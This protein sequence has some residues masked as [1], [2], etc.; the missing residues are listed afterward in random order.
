MIEADVVSE[1]D[2]LSFNGKNCIWCLDD[3]TEK[4]RLRE[5]R[6]H[7]TRHQEILAGCDVYIFVLIFFSTL[8][9]KRS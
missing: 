4:W 1:I 9:D 5:S 8:I 7:R 2:D 3:D 6:C